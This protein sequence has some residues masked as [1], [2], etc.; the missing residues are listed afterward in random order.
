MLDRE[1]PLHVAL[2]LSVAVP[3]FRGRRGKSGVMIK[4]LVRLLGKIVGEQAADV[5]KP[6]ANLKRANT[7]GDFRAVEIAP[8]VMCCS[9]AKQVKGRF[10]L[11]R[12]APRLPLMG[13]T[14]PTNCSCK[15]RKTADRRDSD[16]RMFGSTE[17]NRW[18]V[19]LDSRKQG[20][21]R[22]IEK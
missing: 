7:A 14:M 22:S 1:H 19:G 10:Y 15:F 12:Q 18:F 17:T 5:S 9:A 16:R 4:V 11:L 6:I 8:S 2:F 13:C 21:R 3:K 20:S